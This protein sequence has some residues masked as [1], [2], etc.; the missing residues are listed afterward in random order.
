MRITGIS[1]A[2]LYAALEETSA[3]LYD[4]NLQFNREPERQGSW[5]HF[6]LRVKTCGEPGTHIGMHRRTI[7]ACWH[8]HRDVMRAIFKR[9]PDATLHTG[10]ASYYGSKGFEHEFPYTAH[11]N[12][13][14]IMQ[15][16]ER[17]Q[18]CE[19]NDQE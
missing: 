5:L 17:H 3:K 14:S 19:C 1:S 12:I 15:P 18:A 13:G 9:A 7:Y 10:I 8:A 11:Q 6:T 2:D 4:G 16:R